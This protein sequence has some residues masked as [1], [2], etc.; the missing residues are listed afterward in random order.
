[1]TDS[2]LATVSHPI[3]SRPPI[4]TDGDITPKVVRGFENHCNTYFLNAKDGV[5]DEKKVTRIIGCFENILVD[6]WAQVERDR[7]IELT[8]ETFMKEFRRRWL[9]HNWEQ[10]VRTKMPNSRLDPSQKFETWAAQILSHNV[11]LRNTTSHMN[12]S[13][14]R[15]QL[16]AAL[17]EELRAMATE[18]NIDTETDLRLWM[19][20]IGDIDNRRQLD[21]KRMADFFENSMRSAKRQN[22]GNRFPPPSSTAPSRSAY[23]RGSSLPPPAGNTYPPKLTDDERRLLHEHEGCLKCRVFYAGHRADK[24]TVTLSGKDYKTRT[25]TVALR[26]KTAKPTTRTSTIASVTDATMNTA[27][28]TDL[29][30]AVFPSST[31]ISEE[32]DLSETSERSLSSII[33][34]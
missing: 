34:G 20:K 32:S 2:K 33:F 17:D 12:E 15:T 28:S 9:P 14:L 10:A 7:L 25:I 4:L 11:S 26:A 19:T 21:R 16:E 22:T 29:V 6:D 18:Q 8:F 30:A 23:P 27:A 1:M 24:C 31:T 13:Q 3:M 5:D